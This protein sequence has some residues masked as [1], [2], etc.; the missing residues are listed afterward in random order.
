MT[1][2]VEH[3]HVQAARRTDASVHVRGPQE[4]LRRPPQVGRAGDR[5]PVRDRP[6]RRPAC[7]LPDHRRRGRRS[8]RLGAPSSNHAPHILGSLFPG[9]LRR[10]GSVRPRHLRDHALLPL[11]PPDRRLAPPHPQPAGERARLARAR[12]RDPRPIPASRRSAGS[13]RSWRSA[14]TA[15]RSAR[16]AASSPG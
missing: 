5:R 16:R 2:V 9:A 13:S 7:D 14:G 15:V 3:R 1:I 8:S 11:P 4:R 6:V 12:A 10:T